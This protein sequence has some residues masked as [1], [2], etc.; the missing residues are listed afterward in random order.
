MYMSC[1]WVGHAPLAGDRFVWSIGTSGR[2]RWQQ[3]FW[4]GWQMWQM[5]I[6]GCGWKTGVL[7]RI[8]L[9]VSVAFFESDKKIR[10]APK[11][12]EFYTSW[13]VS[14]LRS[15][16]KQQKRWSKY[17]WRVKQSEF[18]SS[19]S[20]SFAC[21]WLLLSLILFATELFL[22][23]HKEHQGNEHVSIILH[24]LVKVCPTFNCQNIL[25]MLERQPAVAPWLRS[26]PL[27]RR[28][29]THS[30]QN[31]AWSGGP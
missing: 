15:R 30:R 22:K 3:H 28:V 25:P 12:C 19:T 18:V 7:S 14:D 29:A 13:S 21:S 8:S 11:F 4:T 24:A 6:R 23:K 26:C 20:F 5:C 16:N 17:A 31:S 2:L 1:R 10:E 27:E 9:M